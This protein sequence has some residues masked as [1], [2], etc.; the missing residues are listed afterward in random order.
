[1]DQAVFP[2][3]LCNRCSALQRAEERYPIDWDGF[4]RVLFRG[5]PQVMRC[6]ACNMVYATFRGGADGVPHPDLRYHPDEDRVTNLGNPEFGAG[7]CEG[8]CRAFTR[9]W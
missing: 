8:G 3:C 1:M 4:R 7:D 2:D 9:R 6:L 5:G